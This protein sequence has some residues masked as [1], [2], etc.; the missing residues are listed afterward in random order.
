M[1]FPILRLTACCLALLAVLSV[2]TSTSAAADKPNILFIFADDQCF[3]TINSLGNEE[4]QTPNLDRLVARGTTF[5]HAYNM[6]SWSGAVCVASRTMLITGKFLWHAE[7]DYRETSK[8]YLEKGRMW[9]QLMAKA[10]YDTYFTGKWHIRADANKAFKTARNVR[11]GMPNQTPEGYNRPIEGQP[12]K[13]KPW[14]MSFGGFW[15]GGKHWSEVVGDDACDYLDTARKSDNPFFMY[16]AFN[17]PHDPR[18]SPKEYV[19]KYP[20]DKVAVPKNF[21]TEYPYNEAMKSGRGLR[22]EKLAPFPRT[23]YSVKVNRQEYY[24]IITHMDEQIGRILDTLE[25]SGQ[26][27]NTYIF[28]SA[29]HGLAC[30]QHGLMGKQNMF[31]HSVRVPLMVVGPNVP[32]G[33]KRDANVYL[34]DIMATSL[35]LASAERPD[36]V[37]FNSLLPLI[38]DKSKSGYAAVYGAYLQGQ[39]AIT[40]GDYKLILYPEARKTLLF[41]VKTDPLEMDDLSEQPEH[42]KTVKRLFTRLLELQKETGDELD[43]KAAYPTI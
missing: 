2:R 34:Q 26:A 22:D 10:G 32:A 21:L 13:W 16:I 42:Q 19:D 7:K 4:V 28:F 40:V 8:R 15:K 20:L 41:N 25:A 31:D 6:G 23:E 24:A 36:Y 11:G 18:Q 38:K 5:S 35:E 12:M 29:D 27:D 17:A 43:L 30:G 37:Q 9:P 14:D 1:R 33:E 39:R 3:D